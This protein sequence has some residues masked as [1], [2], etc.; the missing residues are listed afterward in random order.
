MKFNR[1]IIVKPVVYV[2]AKEVLKSRIDASAEG[3]EVLVDLQIYFK[4]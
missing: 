4:G 2:I 1:A 3:S